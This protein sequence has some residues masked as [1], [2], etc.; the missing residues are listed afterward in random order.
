MQRK[1]KGKAVG[2]TVEGQGK[3]GEKASKDQGKA[4][5]RNRKAKERQLKGI[6]R[7]RKGGV[8]PA[9][10][11]APGAL[12]LPEARLQHHKERHGLSGERQ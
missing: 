10:R 1:V 8:T 12:G 7:P 2:R 11:A 9:G 3:G 6:G 4:V 5:K